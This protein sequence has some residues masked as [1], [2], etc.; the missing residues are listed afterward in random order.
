MTYSW[1]CEALKQGLTAMK[2]YEPS[3]PPLFRYFLLFRPLIIFFKKIKN[4][5][6]KHKRHF[7]LS[8]GYIL[9]TDYCW[10]RR[11][12]ATSC[13]ILIRFSTLRSSSALASAMP[14]SSSSISSSSTTAFAFAF[15]FPFLV[16]VV[17]RGISVLDDDLFSLSLDPLA[18]GGA[19]P[20][21]STK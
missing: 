7:I 4:H 8:Q 5:Q 19:R 13:S 11:T 12:S 10:E 15:A 6:K 9:I 1:S 2:H 16:R 18:F 17:Q 21:Y 3:P 20:I 14:S